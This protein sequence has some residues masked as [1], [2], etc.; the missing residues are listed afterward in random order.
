MKGVAAFVIGLVAF[1]ASALAQAPVREA[2]ISAA[3]E[4]LARLSADLADGG[5]ADNDAFEDEVREIIA[6]SRARL[7][8]I[9]ADLKRAEDALAILGPAPR[10]GEA[11]EAPALAIERDSLTV[12]VSV[13]RGERTRVLAAID[14]GARLL[15]ELSERRL[16][17]IYRQVL[18]RDAPLV[19]PAVWMRAASETIAMVRGLSKELRQWSGERR[20]A[21]GLHWS[22]LG[23][24]AA[25]GASFLMFG[26]L[27]AWMQHAFSARIE[28]FQPTPGRR[29]AVAGVRMLT[30]LIPG[31]IGG[32]IVIETARALGLLAGGGV[33]V[34]RAFW[35]ALVA[36]LLVDGFASGLFAPTEPAWRLA[37]IDAA[38]G[39]RI[40]RIVLLI[41]AIVG[42]NAVLT[43]LVRAA[44][45]GTSI[46]VTATGVASL[47]AGG[48]FF[49]LC[50]KSLWA[51]ASKDDA[52]PESSGGGPWPTLRFAGRALGVAIIAS[53]LAGHVNLAAFLTTR[54]YYL[55]LLLAFAWFLRA[56]L[57]EIAAWADRRLRAGKGETAPTAEGSKTFEFWIGAGVDAALF[58]L[59]APALFILAGVEWSA[60]R[61]FFLRALVGFR[62]GGV[63]ISLSD[64]ILAIAAFV[65][66]LL[67]TRMLQG[68]LQRGPL[69]YS[70][71]DI[72]IQNSLTTLIGYA[73]L[74]A[75][76]LI[77][78]AILGVNLTN[79]ALIAGALS[80]GIGF[81]LQSIVNN[82]VS[83]LILLFERPI[84]AGDWIVTASGEGV[85]KKIS[86]RSTEVETFDRATI[87]IPNSELVASTVTN[88]THKS[89]LGR[90]TVPIG[91]AYSSDPE[92]VRETLLECARAH[93]FVVSY[94]EPFVVWTSFGASSLDFELRAFIADIS[95]GIQVRTDLRFAIFRAFR[96]KGIE[97]PFP[98]QDI[99][100]RSDEER[101]ARPPKE[102][103][104][105]ARGDAP[106]REPD[107]IDAVDD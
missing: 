99:R 71:I 45:D 28:K 47:L 73:G 19:L 7:S 98:Q 103:A 81:G 97:I 82:F 20:D 6:Q 95:R 66:G 37:P 53:V 43:A 84:K 46:I 63:F 96:E 75:A 52:A 5:A 14:E 100:I 11:P 90:I 39:K 3:T 36:Y 25:I 56:A 60:V 55:A 27:R 48:L 93:P 101:A 1:A 42:A 61:D 40:S 76:A 30:R 49:A 79:L 23:V 89:A 8:P 21:G 50:E 38:K 18:R 87:I 34:A 9:E 59:L 13:L 41:V 24:I 105:Q 94:P 77:A 65:G 58:L 44:G 102:R 35:L 29:V 54:L 32:V 4:A 15:G 104:A 12:R 107:E 106:A 57:K 86:V 17:D 72:G 78:L 70:R 85:V 74:V 88:W 83:G 22:V 26:P 10:E 80:V 67:F 69:A 92:L 91:V 31:V 68:A 16:Q 2:E 62:V 51:S 33:V 64:I